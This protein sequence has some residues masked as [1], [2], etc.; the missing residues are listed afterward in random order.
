[1]AGHTAEKL[2]EDEILAVCSPDYLKRRPGL[3]TPADLLGDRLIHLENV[4]PRCEDW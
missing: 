2:Y 3:R 1:V 4:D